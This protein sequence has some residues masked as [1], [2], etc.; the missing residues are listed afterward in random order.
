MTRT[1]IEGHDAVL[2]VCRA[3]DELSGTV[4]KLGRAVLQLGS[5][6]LELLGAVVEVARTVDKLT[7][8]VLQSGDAVDQ[9]G[10]AVLEIAGAVVGILETVGQLIRTVN[11]ILKAVGK[12]AR[13]I[14]CF[15]K[16]CGRVR[17]FRENGVEVRLCNGGI[18]LCLN[19]RHRSRGQHGR[20]EVVRLVVYENDRALLGVVALGGSH[21]FGKIGRNDELHVITAVFQAFLGILSVGIHPAHT[22]ICVFHGLNEVVAHLE[23]RAVAQFGSLIE[24]DNSNRDLVH[25]S[26]RVVEGPQVQGTIQQRHE[27]NGCHRDLHDCGSPGV[28][29]VE[30]RKTHAAEGVTHS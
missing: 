3:T 17:D 27:G 6:V 8:A 16:V 28:L 24:V 1:V 10:R 7:R 13:T 23:R 9:I 20:N 12:L 26:V 18:E 21:L 29:E 15:L 2:E 25:V 14:N 22:L 19:A 30:Q 5:A 11:C 4:E